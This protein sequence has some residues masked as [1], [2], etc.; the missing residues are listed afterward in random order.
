MVKVLLRVSSAFALSTVVKEVREGGGG[1]S[2]GQ[3]LSW[4]PM[5]EVEEE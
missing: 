4:Q 3:C 5:E 2:G 1:G